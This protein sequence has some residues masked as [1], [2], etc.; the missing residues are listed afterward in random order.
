MCYY[1]KKCTVISDLRAQNYN[2]YSIESILFKKFSHFPNQNPLANNLI[3][4]G[5]YKRIG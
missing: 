1:A 4:P 5:G 3:K 2:H